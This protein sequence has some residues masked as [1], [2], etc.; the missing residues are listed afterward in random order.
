[1]SLQ[2]TSLRHAAA[3]YPFESMLSPD[4]MTRVSELTDQLYDLLAE[5]SRSA[6]LERAHRADIDALTD[7][8]DAI[9]AAVWV[10]E[11]RIPPG[12][13]V[14]VERNGYI[15]AISLDAIA[16]VVMPSQPGEWCL[17]GRIIRKDGRVGKRRSFLFYLEREVLK[18]RG[19]DGAWSDV[20]PW[21]AQA[22]SATCGTA[23]GPAVIPRP[24]PRSTP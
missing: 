10:R 6:K 21:I 11:M 13:I 16:I 14:G 17:T 19:P 5:S 15:D 22:N 18:Q 23:A 9:A 12:S 20:P 4:E 8:I 24:G 7:Q 1:M 2:F 3:T